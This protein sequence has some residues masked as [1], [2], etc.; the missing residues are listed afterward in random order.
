MRKLNITDTILDKLGF[1]EY[2]D[3]HG[4][5]GGRT[6]TF[7]NGTKFRIIE[8]EEM[9][10]EHDGYGVLSGIESTYVAN[11]FYFAGWFAIPKTD[12]GHYDL[13]F[14]HEMYECIEK[15]YPDLV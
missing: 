9:D 7:S 4:T 14:L 6:L 8:Q 1:S 11:H 2:W 13:F 15:E 12:A 3:E 5:W 10:D